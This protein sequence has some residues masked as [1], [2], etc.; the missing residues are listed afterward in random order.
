VLYIYK[1]ATL[2]YTSSAQSVSVNK[3]LTQA[4]GSRREKQLWN[5]YLADTVTSAGL[6]RLPF[7]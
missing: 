5:K 7:I 6:P 3:H 1:L 4:Q 2:N